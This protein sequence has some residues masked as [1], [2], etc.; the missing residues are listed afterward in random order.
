MSAPSWLQ[1]E[2]TTMALCWRLDRGDGQPTTSIVSNEEQKKALAAVLKT[3]SPQVLT[4]PESLLRIL[5][6]RTPDRG[7]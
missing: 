3:L 5:P 2:L 7:G 6:P 1:G 4:L